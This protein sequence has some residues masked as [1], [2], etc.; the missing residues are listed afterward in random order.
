[1]KNTRIQRIADALLPHIDNKARLLDIGCGN[2]QLGRAL[3]E[4]KE[5]DYLGVDLVPQGDS[6][7]SVIQS[8]IPYPFNDASFDTVI[9]ILTLHHLEE[10]LKGLKE[11]AR[12]SAKKLILL[13]DVPRNF[14][15]RLAMMAVDYI[16]NKVVSIK[17][18]V[19]FNFLTDTQW[20]KAFSD[21][22]LNLVSQKKVYPLPFPRL[23]HPLYVLEHSSVKDN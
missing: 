7:M 23:H 15:E 1:M 21:L 19:P 12:L 2:A 22:D 13:E 4:R 10:P 9:V 3:C 20:K 8:D 16:S 14:I 5:I 6:G 11:A 17:I 18:P